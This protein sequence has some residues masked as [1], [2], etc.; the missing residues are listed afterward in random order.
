[1]KFTCAYC[2]KEYTRAVDR[3]LCEVRC[4]EELRKRENEQK[5]KKELEEKNKRLQEIQSTYNKLIE[6]VKSFE[7]NYD[8]LIKFKSN[9]AK[10]HTEIIPP[11]MMS[12]NILDF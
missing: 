10:G 4:N 11:F 9:N 12:Y 7:T 3:A 5:I 8:S 1:M 6:Q 2:G